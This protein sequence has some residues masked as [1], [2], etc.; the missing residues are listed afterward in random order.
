M[1]KPPIPP[2]ETG[3]VADSA[4]ALSHGSPSPPA[5]A[6]LGNQIRSAIIWRSGSQIVGQVIAWVSTFFVIRILAP[7]D[8]G[9]VAMTGV[10]TL[11][12]SLVNGYGF[13]NALIQRKD[14]DR[15]AFRQLFGMLV[16]LN[17]V[18]ALAQIAAAPLAADYFNEP[19]VADLLMVQALVYPTT[20][21]IALAYAI[22]SRGMDFRRQAKVNLLSAT[23][24]AVVAIVGALSGWGVWT[25]VV[26]PLVGLYA[27]AAGLTITAGSLMWPSFDFRGAGYMMR[28]GGLVL[29]SQFLWFL[30]TQADVFIVGRFYNAAELGLYS[31]ALFLTQVFITKVVP[32]LNEVTFSAYSRIK[33]LDDGA[34]TQAFLRSIEMVMMI[35]LP[36]FAGFAVTAEP[37]VLT[38]LG[39]KWAGAI[40]FVALLAIAMPMKTLLALYAPASNA[41]GRPDIP[42][43]NAF[44]GAIILPVVFFLS[45]RWGLIGIAYGWIVAYALLTVVA[46]R[47]TFPSLGVSV[48]R[49]ARVTWPSLVGSLVMAGAVLAVEA[50]A[51]VMPNWV[52][53]IVSMITGVTTYSGFLLLLARKQTLEIVDL[54]LRRQPSGGDISEPVA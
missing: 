36:V 27:R 39:E 31:T 34:V 46:S 47:S 10:V 14:A 52:R 24:G 49:V 44:A 25:I 26:A 50:I 13:A 40:P 20:P 12:L 22:L 29:A 23:I 6:G 3:P 37:L 45:L 42:T 35:G 21:F 15:H 43:R 54:V 9:M 17:L 41:I 1:A 33:D 8:Y 38:V 11:L 2:A 53:L 5:S 19:R 51:P 28:F 30:Q 18:L 48:A 7:E 4:A 32:P 16:L